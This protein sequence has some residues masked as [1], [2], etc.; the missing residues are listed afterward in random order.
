MPSG[1][2]RGAAGSIPVGGGGMMGAPMA[3]AG[4]AAGGGGAHTA[5]SFLHTTDQ[6]GKVVG[7]RSTV[8]PPVIGETDPNDTPDIE[9][10]I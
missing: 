8:A 9:L 2:A 7:N 4:H 5:A 3:G 10:R 6:G 1:S